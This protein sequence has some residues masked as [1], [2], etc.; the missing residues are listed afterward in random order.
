MESQ[1]KVKATVPQMGEFFEKDGGVR[2]YE[3]MDKRYSEEDLK[4]MPEDRYN[5]EVFTFAVRY[6]HMELEKPLTGT[7]TIDGLTKTMAAFKDADR[8][9]HTPIYRNNSEYAREHDEL[10]LYRASNKANTACKEAIE[11]AISEHYYDNVLHKEAVAQVAEKFGY[12]R[13]LYLLAITIRQ[14]DWDGRF[15]ND[16]KE[17]A[18]SVPV[19]ENPDAWGTDRNCYLAI[20]SHSGLVDLFTKLAREEAKAHERKP[21]VLEKLQKPLS[22]PK[23]VSEKS[24]G[25]EL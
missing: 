3:I 17:W 16:N 10:P 25:R 11:K 22:E 2:Y 19:T 13:P 12:E 8:F 23:P 4:A 14:K 18:K 7:F 15:S 5:S 21:S 20:N 9:L 6:R 24:K 1:I